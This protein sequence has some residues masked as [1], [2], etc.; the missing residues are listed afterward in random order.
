VSPAVI[1]VGEV[2]LLSDAE[3]RL[4]TLAARFEGVHAG[5]PGASA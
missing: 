4:G 1:V 5:L 2:V 3:S